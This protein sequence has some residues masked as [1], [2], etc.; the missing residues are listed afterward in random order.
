MCSKVSLYTLKGTV[1]KLISSSAQT[2]AQSPVFAKHCL[3][4]E[5]VQE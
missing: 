4:L 5:Q 2:A 1:L 3:S